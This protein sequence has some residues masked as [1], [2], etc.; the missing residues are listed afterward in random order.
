M[1]AVEFAHD[2]VVKR[3][4]S[5]AGRRTT[6]LAIVEETDAAN[7]PLIALCVALQPSEA[8]LLAGRPIVS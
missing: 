8:L 4:A 5:E 7:A 6:G 2:G 1:G 3:R